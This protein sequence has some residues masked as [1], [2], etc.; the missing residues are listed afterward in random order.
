M[1]HREVARAEFPEQASDRRMWTIGETVR[2]EH[3][4][5]RP[6]GFDGDEHDRGGHRDLPRPL[7]SG[8][9]ARREPDTQRRADPDAVEG[10]GGV[11]T[12]Q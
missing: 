8:G 2:V 11:E 9:D 5:S 12:T 10:R 3:K 1:D 7:R 4:L 6:H